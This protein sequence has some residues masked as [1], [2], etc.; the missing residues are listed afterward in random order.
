MCSTSSLVGK[1]DQVPNYFKTE[2]KIQS[3]GAFTQHVSLQVQ[4]SG[5]YHP[6]LDE[7]LQICGRDEEAVEQRVRK[8]QHEVLVV[9]ESDA[10]V[11]PGGRGGR[12]NDVI[13][14]VNP[15]LISF[16]LFWSYDQLTQH[17]IAAAS[18]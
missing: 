12:G 9:G 10:V 16:S 8:E 13:D 2:L 18:Q 3:K 11:H 1:K 14:R 15:V 5:T 17:L 7:V 6:K 4:T